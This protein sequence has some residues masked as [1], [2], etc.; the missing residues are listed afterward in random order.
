MA[1]TYGCNLLVGGS[2]IGAFILRCVI[3][4][5]VPNIMLLAIYGRSDEFRYFYGLA[6]N[7]LR[8]Q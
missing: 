4:A 1:A 6:K 3:S 7:K 8:K 2:G 5:A